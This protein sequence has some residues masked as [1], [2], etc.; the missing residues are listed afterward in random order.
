MAA[1]SY[2]HRDSGPRGVRSGSRGCRR[3]WPC[4]RRYSRKAFS[5]GSVWRSLARF[6]GLLA[7]D[8][9][10][11]RAYREPFDVAA[12]IPSVLEALDAVGGEDHVNVERAVLQL[13][14]VLP[15]SDLGRLPGCEPKAQLLECLDQSGPVGRGLLDEQ[16]G[17]L[18]GVRESVDD[19]G[20]L[21]DEQVLDVAALEG[22]PQFLDLGVANRSHR[23]CSRA[24]PAGARRTSVGIQPCSRT[25]DIPH[26]RA[27]ACRCGRRRTGGGA[28]AAG[29]RRRR[30][31]IAG[32]DP[33]E[34]VVSH[35]HGGPWRASRLVTSTARISVLGC[36]V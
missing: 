35:G 27:P 19:R 26:R 7:R 18:C 33:S 21:P 24:S 30:T 32:F 22:V 28:G 4:S 13:D 12:P 29:A 34:R 8:D 17:V 5:L 6:G 20:R 23:S 9:V 1:V 31:R 10:V 16:V 2:G 3:W 15:A 11:D 25:I 14:E 36:R